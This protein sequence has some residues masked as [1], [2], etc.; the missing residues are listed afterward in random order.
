M[1]TKIS[2]WC[3]CRWLPYLKPE[4][5]FTADDSFER[6]CLWF[7]FRLKHFM[8]DS[9][10]EKLLLLSNPK[11]MLLFW[12]SLTDFSNL[13]ANLFIK[14]RKR[15]HALKISTLFFKKKRG[16]NFESLTCT[17]SGC[18]PNSFFDIESSKSFCTSKCTCESLQEAGKHK[19]KCSL[20]SVSTR[21]W[22]FEGKQEGE[23][24]VIGGS[25]G[26]LPW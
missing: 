19:P 3:C 8:N 9:N 1:K 25:S 2:Q 18:S 21:S 22:A 13:V 16:L 23:K 5:D 6:N 15:T 7:S 11:A 14:K 17:T 4:T 26:K 20:F 12:S 10:D 24:S